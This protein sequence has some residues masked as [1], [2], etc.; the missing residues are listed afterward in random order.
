MISII[1][2]NIKYI[3]II[4]LFRD[5]NINIIFYYSKFDSS[6][7]EMPIILDEGSN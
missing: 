4:N 1:K 6:N 7:S 5:I 3:F 2:L